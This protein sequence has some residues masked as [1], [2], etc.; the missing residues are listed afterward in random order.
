[1]S[2]DVS[3]RQAAGFPHSP[4]GAIRQQGQ[5]AA[6]HLHRAVGAS[7]KKAAAFFPEVLHQKSWE[8][9]SKSSE[10]VKKMVFFWI[11]MLIYVDV[12]F[13]FDD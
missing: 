6:S 7:R 4:Q 2:L 11:S 12:G 9:A 1:M 8:N 10:N 3:G 5:L 13:D